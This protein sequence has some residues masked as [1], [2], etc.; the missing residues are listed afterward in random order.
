VQIHVYLTLELDD[1]DCLASRFCRFT[2]Y[3]KAIGNRQIGGWLA[4]TAGEETP[5]L[6]SISFELLTSNYTE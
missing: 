2:P 3:E 4:H 5:H 6:S 1:C